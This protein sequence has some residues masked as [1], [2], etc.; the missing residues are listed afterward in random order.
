MSKGAF[1]TFARSNHQQ[2]NLQMATSNYT[3]TD[4]QN[5]WSKIAITSDDNQC[6]LWLA[7]CSKDGY[8]NYRSMVS[9][10]IA[11]SYPNY[12]I[13]KGMKVCHSC[14]NPKCCNP[15]HLFLGTNQ[16]NM[17]DMKKKGRSPNNK[18]E[19]NPRSILTDNQVTEIRKKYSPERR[20][21]S[22]LA[23]EYGISLTQMARIV[24][25]EQWKEQS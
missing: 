24:H 8:G 19:K 12:V 20:N 23:R 4:P 21:R 14:D 6:W 1:N 11:W 13:P 2:R 17:D 25:N 7:G 10:R 22:A 16:D 15:K 18:G 9:H 5:F 3:S